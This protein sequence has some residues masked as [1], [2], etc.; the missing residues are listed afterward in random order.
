MFVESSGQFGAAQPG[1]L[2]TG[3]AISNAESPLPVHVTLDLTGLAGLPPLLTGSLDIPAGGQTARFLNQIPGFESLP[4]TFQGVLRI[5]S[6][7]SPVTVVG[8]RGRYNER[9]DFIEATIPAINEND[10]YFDL[11]LRYSDF[12]F[13][14]FADGGGYTTQFVLFSGWTDGPDNGTVQFLTNAG[15]PFPLTLQVR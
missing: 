4:A 14:H 1:S 3:I 15:A 11:V 9:G 8:I 2:Q 10:S 7:S 13:P 5:S 6:P 12:V